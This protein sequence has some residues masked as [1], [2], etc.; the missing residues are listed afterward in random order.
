LATA[1]FVILFQIFIAIA[2]IVFA[3]NYLLHVMS[4]LSLMK[5]LVVMSV[6]KLSRIRQRCV[7]HMAM[8]FG[9]HIGIN[10][11]EETDRG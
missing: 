7:H 5:I 10:K 6:G 3:I 4:V 1:C 9:C 11:K 8:M 2:P